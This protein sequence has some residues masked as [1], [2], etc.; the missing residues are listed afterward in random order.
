V[1][2]YILKVIRVPVHTQTATG[3]GAFAY[4]INRLVRGTVPSDRISRRGG[5][6]RL[7]DCALLHAVLPACRA[8][9]SGAVRMMQVIFI[10]STNERCRGG[11]FESLLLQLIISVSTF[12]QRRCS[13]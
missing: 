12:M 7:H 9:F 8:F 1:G 13:S 3:T 10:T 2:L 5:S 11:K 4:Y 6:E